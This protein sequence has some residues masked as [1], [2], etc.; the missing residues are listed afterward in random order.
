VGTAA[1]INEIIDKRLQEIDQEIQ[2]FLPNPLER[3][4]LVRLS[5][6]AHGP[7]DRVVE[8]TRREDDIRSEE[9]SLPVRHGPDSL[10]GNDDDK[11]WEDNFSHSDEED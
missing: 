4:P 10:I 3:G 6:N 5:P 7:D 8:D 9:S 11:E 2:P 1:E